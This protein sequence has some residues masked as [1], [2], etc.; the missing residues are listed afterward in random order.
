M[1]YALCIIQGTAMTSIQRL[2]KDIEA[3]PSGSDIAAIF[4]FYGTI[5]AGY[6][7]PPFIKEQVR[8]G[9]LSPRQLAEIV[10]AMASFG[11]GNLG[12]SGM[13]AVNAQFMRGIEE[14]S[15]KEA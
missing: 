12:F 10:S 13:M 2:L 3:A 14:A 1:R 15:Y 6:S 8:R 9:D 11:L 4:D 5:N 7:A